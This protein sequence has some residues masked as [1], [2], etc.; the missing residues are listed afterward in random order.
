MS[1]DGMS[2]DG[3]NDRVTTTRS[4]HVVFQNLRKKPAASRQ[5]F[6]IR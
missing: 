4:R 5:Q 6:T 2:H 1:H 3:M